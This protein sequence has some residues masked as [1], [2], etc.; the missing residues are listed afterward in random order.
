MVAMWG[1]DQFYHSLIRKYVAVF[2]SIFSEVVIQRTDTNNN[3]TQ[4]MTVPLQYMPKEKAF[5]RLVSDPDANRPYAVN[6]PIMTFEIKNIVYDPERKLN[7]MV[8]NVM[9]SPVDKNRF[10]TI[11]QPMPYDIY[12]DLHVYVKNAEDA[13][14]IVEQILPYFVP[15]WTPLVELIPEM[16]EYRDVPIVLKNVQISDIMGDKFE[17]RR[18]LIWTLQF[19]MNAYFYGPVLPRPMI[20][21]TTTNFDVP[22]PTLTETIAYP[23]GANTTTSVPVEVDPTAYTVSDT[24]IS[25]PGLTSNGQP[26]VSV[27]NSINYTLIDINDDWGFAQELDIVNEFIRPVANT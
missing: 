5:V 19:Q 6:L 16:N 2:G 3:V 14:K 23:Q 22:D 25:Q 10:R 9:R 8:R 13:S 12:F 17:N 15:A 26:T 4:V 20:K 1:G 11:Y 7:S 27:N 21:F 18:I 24:I